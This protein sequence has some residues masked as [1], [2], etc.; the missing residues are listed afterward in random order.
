[1]VEVLVQLP[2]IL[3]PAT[4]VDA[5]LATAL[6]RWGGRMPVGA[7]VTLDARRTWFADAEV[8]RT[9]ATRIL[10]G[11]PSSLTLRG[12]PSSAAEA[13]ADLL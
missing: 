10:R 3:G 9:I 13:I 4:D 6:A 8:M 1:M 2:P 5:T 12:G 11:Q 7:A